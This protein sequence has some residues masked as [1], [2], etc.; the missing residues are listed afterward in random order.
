MT[1]AKNYFAWQSRLVARELGQRVVEVGCGIGNFTGLLLDRELVVALDREDACIQLLRQRYPGR[2]NLHA[3]TGDAASDALRD[4]ARFRPDSVVCV[5]VLEHIEDDLAALDAMASILAPGGVMVLLVPAFQALYGPIDRHL[6]HYR[7][8]RRGS[9]LR[10][11]AAAGVEVRKAHYVNAAGFFGWW[12][13]AHILKREAQSD[14]QI[15]VFDRYLVPI[16]SALEG[17]LP[18]PFGQS[19]LAVLRRPG[20]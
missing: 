13:N 7:R 5:N 3:F 15:A 10:L 14:G 20:L 6:G 2:R 16:L 1:R 8:Y 4:L 19:L 11:A 17:V 12:V 9:L 18:P